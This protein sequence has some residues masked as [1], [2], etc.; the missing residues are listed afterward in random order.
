MDEVVGGDPDDAF[1]RLVHAR[2]FVPSG[3]GFSALAVRVRALR[4]A[5][6]AAAPP[7][8]RLGGDG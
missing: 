2:V 7:P 3:G 8:P 4:G 6:A 5:A 1:L